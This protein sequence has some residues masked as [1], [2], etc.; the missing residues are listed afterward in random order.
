MMRKGFVFGLLL[1][2]ASSLM[3]ESNRAFL[4]WSDF[5]KGEFHSVDRMAMERRSTSKTVMRGGG[6]YRFYSEDSKSLTKWIK[7]RPLF[8]E[9]NDTLYL[10]CRRLKYDGGTFGK[11]YAPALLIDNII[12]FSASPVGSAYKGMGGLVGATV[13]KDQR[14]YYS[15][16]PS[17]GE[18]KI[19]GEPDI[20]KLIDT[21]PDLKE[22]YEKDVNR[23]D[24]EVIGEYLYKIKNCNSD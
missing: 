2:F 19:L 9:W 17:N 21:C 4:S 1:F 14:V 24:I 15:L 23:T 11:W 10:N 20:L 5:L 22:A 7:E 3:A 8:I 18:M 13:A 16:N 12:Y 6:D